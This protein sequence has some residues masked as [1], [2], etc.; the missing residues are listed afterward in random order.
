MVNWVHPSK[1]KPEQKYIDYGKRY[2]DYNNLPLWCDTTASTYTTA[3]TSISTYTAI[4]RVVGT[5]GVTW[6][7]NP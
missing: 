7:C 5:A 3:S 4:A 2:V 1:R 6:W